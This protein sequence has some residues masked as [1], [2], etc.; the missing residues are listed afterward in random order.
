MS[1]ENRGSLAYCG[2]NNPLAVPS[3]IRKDI[4]ELIIEAAPSSLITNGLGRWLCP[5]C[6]VDKKNAGEYWLYLP[7]FGFEQFTGP[8]PMIAVPKEKSSNEC[9]TPAATPFEFES[10]YSYSES[11]DTSEEVEYVDDKNRDHWTYTKYRKAAGEAAQKGL[12][13]DWKENFYQQL[14]NWNGETSN[15]AFYANLPQVRTCLNQIYFLDGELRRNSTPCGFSIAPYFKYEFFRKETFESKLQL[16]MQAMVFPIPGLDGEMSKKIA[17]PICVVRRDDLKHDE[18]FKKHVMSGGG[19]L[20]VPA[21]DLPWPLHLEGIEVV[22]PGGTLAENSFRIYM[23]SVENP[24]TPE[25]FEDWPEEAQNKYTPGIRCTNPHKGHGQYD[26]PCPYVLGMGVQYFR[27]EGYGVV[28]KPMP[29]F[30]GPAFEKYPKIS[31]K[32]LALVETELECDESEISK[33]MEESLQ[34]IKASV[35]IYD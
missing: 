2:S 28:G 34:D 26:T 21:K 30:N 11:S 31:P 4:V 23:N 8:N 12:C 20:P 18:D 10:E 13:E 5:R 27:E 17:C 32:F 24:E 33:P 25:G 15:S 9:Q 7:A 22:K 16:Q 14:T 19:Y 6:S 3:T 29:P 1:A 35:G